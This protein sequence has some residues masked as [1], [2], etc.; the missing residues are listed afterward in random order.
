ME[1][2][3]TFADA[4]RVS[5]ST[6]S[7]T[8]ATHIKFIFMCMHAKYSASL[9]FHLFIPCNRREGN[10]GWKFLIISRF[11]YLKNDIRLQVQLNILSSLYSD[12][13]IMIVNFEQMLFQ[14]MD[15]FA[16]IYELVTGNFVVLNILVTYIF[17]SF[18]FGSW[19]TFKFAFGQ[20][21]PGSSVAQ[22]YSLHLTV[23]YVCV[24][25]VWFVAPKI[26]CFLYSSV[27][28]FVLVLLQHQL[29]VLALGLVFM[30]YNNQLFLAMC[31]DLLISS[32]SWC[33]N[34]WE[35]VCVCV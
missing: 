34:V 2:S 20:F 8:S 12:Y 30:T 35:W 14:V 6:S 9:Q 1:L 18:S 16:V 5:T 27:E 26:S 29:L 31:L 3:I 13:L 33:V 32:G 21:E 17:F 11:V 28:W 19:L 24:L 7:F 25:C 15:C 10:A 23:L 22:Q 4:K